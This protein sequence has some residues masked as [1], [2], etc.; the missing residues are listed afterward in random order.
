[1]VVVNEKGIDQLDDDSNRHW[2][3]KVTDRTDDDSH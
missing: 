1:M 2:M 3:E